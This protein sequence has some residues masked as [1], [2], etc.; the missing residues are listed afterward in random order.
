MA[1]RLS[2]Q[3]R[4]KNQ[5]TLPKRLVDHVDLKEGDFLDFEL[6]TT[7]RSVP[8]GVIILHKKRLAEDPLPNEPL[9]VERDEN[10]FPGVKTA[11]AE[12]K[13]RL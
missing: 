5:I 12:L 3:I 9:P 8:A 13:K 6:V 11:I 1:K 7:P 4:A 10:E 2:A